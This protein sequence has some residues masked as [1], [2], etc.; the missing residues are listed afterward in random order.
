MPDIDILVNDEDEMRVGREKDCVIH[1]KFTVLEK[2]TEL[3]Y[4]CIY[5][6]VDEPERVFQFNRNIGIKVA[7]VIYIY[8]YI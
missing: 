3:I 5:Y 2:Y 7:F 8:I 1:H 4:E 6:E